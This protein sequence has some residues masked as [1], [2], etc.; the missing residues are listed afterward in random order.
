MASVENPTECRDLFVF[1]IISDGK[2]LSLYI[3]E[4][5]LQKKN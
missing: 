4:I 2:K 1:F 5:V 3:S